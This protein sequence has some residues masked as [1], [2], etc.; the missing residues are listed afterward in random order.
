MGSSHC[1]L[2][3]IAIPTYNRADRYLGE[4]LESAVRQTYDSIEIIVADNCSTDNT[5]IVVKGFNDPR[6]RYFKHSENMGPD[7]NW[8]FCLKQ[9]KGAYFLLLQ[10]DDLIDND[11][12]DVCMKAVNFRTD[13][14]IIR[15][16]TRIIDSSGTIL[17]EQVNL[18]AGL[19]TEDFIIAFLSQ[20]LRMFLCGS[21]FN[22]TH[23]KGIGVFYGIWAGTKYR[24]WEDV[25]TEFQL[26]T[27]FGRI[28]VKDI[29]ACY[30]L[31]SSALTFNVNTREWVE[32][33]VLLLDFLCD[34]VPNNKAFIKN[35]GTQ[36]FA[37]TNY[38]I[39][40][41]RKSPT[42]RFIAY[43]IVYKEFKVFKEFKLP[44][45]YRLLSH[46]PFYYPLRFIKRKVW[47]VLK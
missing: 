24:H 16:G 27:R 35:K 45:I 18:A 6:I 15:T 34:L 36:Y 9:A 1:P 25:Y 29:K 30:R 14:G 42:K 17:S 31:H 44:S 26:A 3:T 7:P 5:E 28:D 21:L 23:L 37:R 43:L 4:A 33:S 32:D 20:K 38:N 13:V 8:N 40:S 19:S 22:T 39:A 11:F 12:V 41:R 10:D 46:T 47:Q 2:V